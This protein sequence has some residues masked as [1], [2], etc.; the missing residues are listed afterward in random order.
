LG[1]TL[2]LTLTSELLWLYQVTALDVY[3]KCLSSKLGRDAE[4]EIDR[5]GKTQM[6]LLT[7]AGARPYVSIVMPT[8]NEARFIEQTLKSLQGQQTPGFELEILVVDG[9]SQDGTPERVRAMAAQDPRI[10]LLSN[11]ARHTPA[12]LNIGLRAAAGEYVCIMGA[13]AAYQPDYVLVCLRE[14]LANDAVGCSGKVVTTPANSSLQARLVAWTS[15]HWFA[16][17]SRSV[18]TQPEGYA[19]T[20]PFPV[21]RKHDLLK[22]GGYNEHLIRNQD[23]DMNQ[24]LRARGLKLYV[25]GKTQCRYYARANVPSLLRY[26]FLSGQWNALSLRTNAASLGLRHLV[27]LA[28]V[29]MLLILVAASVGGWALGLPGSAAGLLL[30]GILAS[31]LLIGIA[32]GAGVAL[33]EKTP[34]A[35]LIAPLIL[36]FHCSYG[37]GTLDGI[38]TTGRPAAVTA[39]SLHQSSNDAA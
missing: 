25:T 9:K 17:S 8:F 13:H 16:S 5:S 1:W 11:P 22:A 4:K 15:G 14:L 3:G 24:R 23:N 31:H 35:I 39:A 36:A 20:V 32:A 2:S 7:G 33:R 28:F 30:L 38:L 26:A 27:P 19:D 18:R 12:A 29:T 6:K 34:A 37:M 21:M 10:K